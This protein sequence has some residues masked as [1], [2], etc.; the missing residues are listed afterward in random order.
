MTPCE[1]KGYKVGD[2]FIVNNNAEQGN[3]Y[4]FRKGDIVTLRK[5]DGSSC[6]NFYSDKADD[7]N[8]L[9]LF[10]VDKLPLLQPSNDTKLTIASFI[11]EM[12]DS[13]NVC[14]SIEKERTSIF[15]HGFEFTCKNDEELLQKINACL[16]LFKEG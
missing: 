5:D 8:Y 7:D 1:E 9:Y 2:K 16:L 11:K 14:V 6:P 12:P 10:E 13:T 3:H 15:V 4:G